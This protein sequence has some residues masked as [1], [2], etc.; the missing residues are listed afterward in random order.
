LIASAEEKVKRK[1]GARTENKPPLGR[2]RR[3]NLMDPINCNRPTQSSLRYVGVFE[4][5]I[6][7]LATFSLNSCISST[8]FETARMLNK[9]KIE[10]MPY[11]SQSKIITITDYPNYSP[12][13]VNSIY[14]VSIGYGLSKELNLLGNVEQISIGSSPGLYGFRIGIKKAIRLNKDAFSFSLGYYDKSL[15]KLCANG[16]SNYYLTRKI[17]YCFD[18][19]IN[20][21]IYL[22]NSTG[23]T[24]Y[25]FSAFIFNNMTFELGKHF[26]IRPEVSFDVFKVFQGI[27][28][29]NYGIA[30]GLTF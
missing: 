10:I 1:N 19:A 4:L 3:I 14:G 29:F 28:W 7:L 15:L 18:P 11:V 6:I 16:Y 12:I 13:D 30:G 27:F 20:G 25:Y 8:S 17:Y 5:V 26:Y 2:Q 9:N 22:G 24:G 23:E 21:L